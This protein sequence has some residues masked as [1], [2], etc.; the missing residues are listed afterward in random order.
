[1]IDKEKRSLITRTALE[2]ASKDSLGLTNHL[3]KEFGI[4]RQSANNHVKALVS[5]GLLE[6]NGVTRARTYR[7]AVINSAQKRYPRKGLAEDIAWR[8][9]F[10]PIVY[11]LP[12]NVRRI[13]QYGVTEMVNNAIDHSGS[14]FVSV[15]ISRN[16]LFTD[17]W[18]LDEG[19]GIF[20]K[21][22]KALGLYDPREAI[23]ELAK[24]KLT[25]EPASHT[26][27]GI[28]FTSKIFDKF[29][30]VSGKLHFLHN[31][32]PLDILFERPEDARGTYVIMRLAN[33]SP[34]TIKAVM[35][36]FAA[37]EEYSFA[38]TIVPVKLALYEGEALVSRSQAKRLSMRF[39]R[40]RYVVLDFSGVNEIGQAFADELFRIFAEAHPQVLLTWINTTDA[41]ENM[42]KRVRS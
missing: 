13:W 38:K 16:A 25:T 40:F 34:R 21:I 3:V 8:D 19:E 39:E 32:K 15:G 12:E 20:L 35:D 2:F 33:D 37:P 7:L 17:G 36:E 28:F 22:Q 11:D 31:V 9:V 18:V 4:S 30:I 5:E 23:L 1:M 10:A 42:I 24:G 6:A 29:D 14:E 27:E 26:G 41:V